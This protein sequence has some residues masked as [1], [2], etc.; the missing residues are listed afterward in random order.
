MA[1]VSISYAAKYAGMSRTQLYRGYLKKG[2]IST[3]TDGDKT[4]KIDTS[5]L[6]RVFGESKESS[7]NGAA[8]VHNVPLRP[9]TP[10][11]T[12]TESTILRQKV[13]HLEE[14]LQEKEKRLQEK[15]E[16]ISELRQAIAVISYKPESV[17]VEP[18]PQPVKRGFFARLFGR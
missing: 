13:K 11:K 18:Q 1:L 8:T 7:S 9:V 15:D 5:E 4:P 2:K 10:S 16:R 6:L 3:V 12:D 14:L 17:P